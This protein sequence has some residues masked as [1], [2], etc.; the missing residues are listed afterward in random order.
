VCRCELTN[1]A[2]LGGA[3]PRAA[4]QPP[5]VARSSPSTEAVGAR[6]AAPAGDGPS[7]P[8]AG[9]S[10]KK[11]AETVRV[12]IDRL[13][14]LMNLAGQLVISRARF[15][16]ISDSLRSLGR[17]KHTSH[18]VGNLASAVDALEELVDSC[19]DGAPA[20]DA[21]SSLK[22]HARRMR[23]DLAAVLGEL[24]TLTQL[25]RSVVDLGEAVHQLGR[26]ADGLQKGVMDT[27][28]LPIGPLFGRFKRVIRDITRG[29]GREIALEIAGENTELDKRMI[30]EL[31]DPLI[32]LVRNAA[33]H[34]IESPAER[35]AAGKPPQGS[36]FLNAFHRGNQIVIQVRDDGRGIDPAKVRRKAVEKGLLSVADAEKLTDGQALQLIW[37]PGFS[38]ADRVTEVS[39]RGMG[40]DIVKT[41]IEDLNGSVEVDSRMGEGAAFT[42]KLP[43]TLA[44]LPS[45]LAEIDGD[46]YAIPIESV[47]EIVQINAESVSTIGGRPCARIRDRVVAMA[48]LAEVYAWSNPPQSGRWQ[49]DRDN[50][51]VICGV[52][53]REVAL[54]V[55]HVLGE[56]DVVIKSLAENYQS[57]EGVS[58]AS[59]LG[60]GRV[61]LILDVNFLLD[62][63]LS[64]PQCG[65]DAARST[66][67][68]G[69]RVS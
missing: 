63:A 64:G 1:L 15:S 61:S 7:P 54:I 18:G 46:A 25:P 45:L 41:K 60:D 22:H 47:L 42:I 11:P 37:E 6:P 4:S 69:P 53:R 66:P 48:S 14:E 16:Q 17:L 43:L 51:L 5:V 56:D 49:D 32:H 35:V 20:R 57:V 2:A 27:R 28:M 62:R 44:I 19:H 23:D 30:D 52:D 21:L 55:D 38:T 26:I 59:L 39:G 29:N 58:G 36:V 34:G 24:Q 3:P 8:K 68:A 65:S 13:D 50:L 33:D 10:R 9:D 40:M 12:E 67:P 31:G